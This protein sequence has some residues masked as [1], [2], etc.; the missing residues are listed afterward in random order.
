[1][2]NKCEQLACCNI[3]EKSQTQVVPPPPM[4][5]EMVR[6]FF[7]IYGVIYKLRTESLIVNEKLNSLEILNE[8]DY[9]IARLEQKQSPPTTKFNAQNIYGRYQCN[10]SFVVF[11]DPYCACSKPVHYMFLNVPLC[12][13]N[14]CHPPTLIFFRR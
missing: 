8:I 5:V 9:N 14:R 6:V 13:Q 7:Y 12:L 11:F 3:N 1:M 4:K 2:K 10:K